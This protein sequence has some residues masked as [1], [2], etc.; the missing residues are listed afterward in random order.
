MNIRSNLVTPNIF[1]WDVQRYPLK[2]FICGPG[3]TSTGFELRKSV[4]EYVEGFARCETTFGEDVTSKTIAVRRADLQ[5]LE[6]Q[7]AQSVDFTLL[8]LDSPGAIA[9]LGTFS[10][11]AN[12][13]PRLYVLVPSRHYGAESYI[14]RGPLSLI[15]RDF[16]RHV[17]YFDGGQD[18]SIFRSLDF[19]ISMY[20]FAGYKRGREYKSVALSDWREPSYQPESYE[21]YFK[22]IRAEFFQLVVL[23][24]IVFLD[25]PTFTEIVDVTQ[26]HPDEISSS[27]KQLH[28]Q[29]RILKD[30]KGR[31]VAT[32]GYDDGMLNPI[33]SKQLSRARARHIAFD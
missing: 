13:R 22:P 17:I 14:A 3:K 15:A 30:G 20:K 19:I 26:M 7:L 32:N 18:K 5:T 10:M 29:N 1:K 21:K 25:S 6:S 33:D 31:Y 16:K 27:L 24:T 9:E 2:V 28:H 23:S 11:I 8:L 12:I 4:K